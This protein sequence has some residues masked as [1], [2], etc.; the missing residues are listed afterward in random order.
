MSEQDKKRFINAI[1]ALAET[2]G[3]TLTPGMIRGYRVGLEG[4]SVEEVEAACEKALRSERFMPPPAALR[5]LAGATDEAAA[6]R[7]WD[8][9]VNAIRSVGSYRG[10]TFADPLIA[11]A[12]HRCGGWTHVCGLGG[13]ELH[14]WLRRTFLE[15]YAALATQGVPDGDYRL[16]G[17]HETGEAAR[18]PAHLRGALAAP[19]VKA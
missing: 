13:D 19:G 5:D 1:G 6:T 12:V 17:H 8:E 9:V 14:K 11:P 7:A 3:K 4:P 15:E 2:F 16:L 18:L 10:P